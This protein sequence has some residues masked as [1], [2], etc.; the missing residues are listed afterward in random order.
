MLQAIL[1]CSI[2]AGG[3]LV[4]MM[5]MAPP[6]PNPRFKP[7]SSTPNRPPDSHRTS[8]RTAD[9]LPTSQLLKRLAV[10]TSMLQHVVPL[11]DEN[12]GLHTSCPAQDAENSVPS[13]SRAGTKSMGPGAKATGLNSQRKAL[14]NITNIGRA[15]DAKQAGKGLSH[16]SRKA[17]ED[18]T[19]A[20][21]RHKQSAAQ[22]SA[23]PQAQAKKVRKHH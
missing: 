1:Q 8:R 19:N 18:L 13:V 12:V 11:Q 10:Q 16:G 7:Y 2:V 3:G 23:A 22:K 17:L 9:I 4:E 5:E 20:T 21:P 15:G 14:G 6:S